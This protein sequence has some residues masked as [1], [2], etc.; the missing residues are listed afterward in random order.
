MDEQNIS[1]ILSNTDNLPEGIPVGEY[2]NRQQLN[3]ALNTLNNANFPLR[4][5]FIQ[6]EGLKQIEFLGNKLSYPK[7]ALASAA[8]GAFFGAFIGLATALLSN[9]NFA[10]NL[11]SSIPLGIAVWMIFGVLSYSRSNKQGNF[12]TR[13]QLVPQK[14]IL[15]AHPSTAGQ[16]Q[17]ILGGPQPTP[18][19]PEGPVP[20]SPPTPPQ[21]FDGNTLPPQKTAEPFPSPTVNSPQKE[22]SSKFGLRIE[23]PEEY[24]QTIRQEPPAPEPN[25]RIEQIRSQQRTGRYGIRIENPEQFQEAI[26]QPGQSTPPQPQPSNTKPHNNSAGTQE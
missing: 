25:E 6:G 3:Q 20:F 2:S 17:H 18:M 7:V 16:A 26:R 13:A 15:M 14:Y 12:Q 23:D 24:A 11:L 5:L 19:A 4:T 8:Q 9:G 10:A 21:S 22:S 1:A